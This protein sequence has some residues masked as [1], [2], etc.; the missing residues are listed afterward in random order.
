MRAV[1]GS[2]EFYSCFLN[3]I[4]QVTLTKAFYMQTTQVTH[5]QWQLLMDKNPSFF[6]NCEDS[7]PV[8]QISWYDAQ[9]FIQRLNQ[10]ESANKYRLPTEA[11]WE[12]AC[13]S[14][15]DTKFCFGDE[16]VS[17][18]VEPVGVVLGG[19]VEDGVSVALS[20]IVIYEIVLETIVEVKEEEPPTFESFV[21]DPVVN[22]P[23]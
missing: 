16:E 1:P 2:N 13:R 15:S 6:N 3:P 18:T 17:P 20:D 21:N 9:E 7:C 4:H 12:Y 22:S 11:E 19:P 8:E 23:D 5:A 14:G 10:R